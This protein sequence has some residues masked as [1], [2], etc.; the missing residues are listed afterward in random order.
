M[1]IIMQ[2]SLLCRFVAST[3]K[4]S[5]VSVS[6]VSTFPY[7]RTMRKENGNNQVYYTRVLWRCC[8]LRISIGKSLVRQD[9]LIQKIFPIL[10]P[11]LE[12]KQANS[13]VL[14]IACQSSTLGTLH[15][16]HWTVIP[17]YSWKNSSRSF[18]NVNICGCSNSWYKMV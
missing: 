5:Y 18:T 14:K 10:E 12:M 13:H 4:L 11:K 16:S 1:C 3:V 17:S 2:I 6:K 15:G 7:W 8:I 9:C